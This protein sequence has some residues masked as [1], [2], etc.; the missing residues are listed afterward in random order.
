MSS[1]KCINLECKDPNLQ[2]ST[3]FYAGKNTCKKC[4]LERSK[5]KRKDGRDDIE[6]KTLKISEL[7]NEIET[8]KALNSFSL[9]EPT[10]NSHADKQEIQQ[11]NQTIDRQN[12]MIDKLN[13]DL[14]TLQE[15][16][17]VRDSAISNL[18]RQLQKNT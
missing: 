7:E 10:L 17:D 1:K 12:E 6:E 5:N 16:I 4:I 13:E 18:K 14:E 8:L 15:T 9:D 11:L 3:N 2:P